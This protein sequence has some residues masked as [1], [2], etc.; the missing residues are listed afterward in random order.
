MTGESQTARR[1][2]PDP[3]LIAA[4]ADRR[5][6]GAEAARMDEHIAGCPDC[7]EV[8]AETLRFSLSEDQDAPGRW[9]PI[10][11]FVRQ[12]ALKVAAGLAIAAS[13]LL[14]IRFYR[15]PTP[16]AVPLIAE[17]AAAMG[18]R[19]IIEPRLTRFQYGRLIVLR[20]GDTP[21][22]LDAQT[23]AVLAAVARIRERAENDPS[24]EALGALGVTYLVSG[25]VYEAVK[26]LESATAQDPENARLLT[27]LS[28]A[29]LVRATQADEPADIPKALESAET[30]IALLDPPVEAWFN[31]ALA[32]EALHLVDAARKAWEDYLQRDSSSGWAEEARQHLERLPKPRQS[33]AEEDKARVRAVLEKRAA[34]VESLAD[35][36]PQLLRNY[37][38]DEVLP[39][40]AD[41]Y[42]VGHPDA[43]L[44]RERAG[45][46]GEALLRTTSDA[47]PRDA[48]RALAE[49]TPTAASRNPLRSQALGYQALREAKRLYDLQEPCCS[50]FRDALTELEAGG[51]PYAAWARVQTV[52]A[53]RFDSEPKAA[54]AELRQMESFAERQAYVQ[55]L[56]RAHWL[57]GLRQGMRGELTASLEQYRS[58][59]A[60]FQASRHAENE[61]MA[62]A[63]LAENFELL[64]ESRNAWR[65]RHQTFGLLHAVRA[66]RRRHGMLNE[67]IFACLDERM[68]RSALHFGTALVEMARSS[69]PDDVS[70]ALQRRAAIYHVLGADDLAAVDMHEA[71]FWIPRI[72]EKSEAERVEAEAD[73]TEGEILIRRKPEAAARSL[74]RSLAYFRATSPARVPALQLLLARAQAT[75]SFDIEAE[76]ELLVGIEAMER[77]RIPL[78]DASLQV[79]FFDQALPLFDD[80]VRLQITK[81]RNPERALAFVERGL[82]R[83][84]VDALAGAAVTPLEPEALRRQL[85]EGLT[86][87]YY[88]PLD[89]GLFVWTLSRENLHFIER[90]LPAAE[91]SRLVAAHR[92]AIERR[93][94]L[95]I[96]RR[97]AARLHDELVRPLISFFASQRAL[98]FIPGSVLQSVAFAGLWNTE[99]GRYLVEDYLLG[100]SPSGT[101][102][103]RASSSADRALSTAARALVVGNPRPDRRVWGGFPNLPEAEAEADEVSSL[104]ARSALLTQGAATKTA[105]LEGVRGSQVVH[106]A[107]HAATIASAPSS[108]RLL[109]AGDPKTGDSGALYLHELER[110]SFAGTRVVVLAA[111]RTATGTVSRVEGALSLGRPFL[112]VGVPHVVA[113]LWDIDDAVSR[114]FFVGFHRALLAEGDPVLALRNAQIA[115]LRDADAALSHPASWAAFICMGGFDPHSLSKGE[116]S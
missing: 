116:T 85:P 36:D 108:A 58:A 61:A 90:S 30:A 92:T 62:L 69:S 75:R 84:L 17:L 16:P 74:A 68:P 106:Y 32:L 71:R 91:L 40:W 15:A 24:P 45:L 89:D 42:L 99:T 43:K 8:F 57:L 46:L 5:L 88:V 4:H 103:V 112:A 110:S 87:V 70:E 28:A 109:L 82:G 60:A 107:G 55:L 2:C 95:D 13:L 41:A 31:R 52:S 93:A 115:F 39:S 35:E 54:M 49:P 66:L 51:S 100:V 18:T 34:A 11:K 33:S 12:P 53:C 38:E 27:D 37:L 20:S 80:M 64:G 111:C 72:P 23:P 67:A 14:A 98:V 56:G 94:P 22:G 102:L 105:F 19:R 81:R 7:S 77:G 9:S 104:Y 63:L 79:S 21:N 65:H 10:A 83:Q 3:G 50:E 78:R 44:F 97:T 86:L 113:S 101:V 73:A 47:M 6:S 96:V 25:N 59:R 1:P 29:Y 114:R 76:E 26:A 48:A